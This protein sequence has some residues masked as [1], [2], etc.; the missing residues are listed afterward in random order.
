MKENQRLKMLYLKQLFEQ[1]T[2]EDHPMTMPQILKYL[3]EH[4]ISAERKMIYQDI[5][6]LR[7]FG[8]DIIA[9]KRGRET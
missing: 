8:M 6:E 1:E 7:N 9:D 4:E 3:T 2:D 5:A